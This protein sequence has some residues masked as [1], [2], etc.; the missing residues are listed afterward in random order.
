MTKWEVFKFVALRVPL[1]VFCGIRF[2]RYK[3]GQCVVTMRRNW[4]NRNPYKAAYFASVMAAGEM[5]AGIPLFEALR[6]AGNVVAVI[7]AASAKFVRPVL[8]G[9]EASFVYH[10]SGMQVAVNA[11]REYGKSSIVTQ[12][13]AYNEQGML[14]ARV[15]ITWKLRRI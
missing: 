15:E 12:T 4:R 11:A 2:K 1:V 13:N 8:A 9:N 14:I 7:T 10:P 3:H 6:R 5:A